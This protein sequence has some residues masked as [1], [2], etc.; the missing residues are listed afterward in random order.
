MARL[1]EVHEND[2]EGS[3]LFRE[4]GYDRGLLLLHQ[5]IRATHASLLDLDLGWCLQKRPDC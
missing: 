4:H 3:T 5:A 1:V 2:E